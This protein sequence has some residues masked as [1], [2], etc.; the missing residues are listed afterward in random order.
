MADNTR[1]RGRA[2]MAGT[3]TA[4]PLQPA[5]P[6]A[7]PT[8]SSEPPA[9]QPTVLTSRKPGTDIDSALAMISKKLDRLEKMEEKL[10]GLDDMRV[11]LKDLGESAVEMKKMMEEDRQAYHVEAR[12]HRIV[13]QELA[14][15]Q[16]TNKRLEMQINGLFNHQKICNL[17]V[18]GKPEEPNENLK[19]FVMDLAGDMGVT[20]L[21]LG[22]IMTAYR[23]GKMKQ[24]TAQTRPRTIMVTF[25]NERVRN[26]VFYARSALKDKQQYRGIFVN[27]DVTQMTRRQRDDFRAVA[28]LARRDGVEVRVHTDGI[29]LNG[30]KHLLASP[31]TL[32]EEYTVAKA[33]TVELDGE[34]Y[35]SSESSFL[36]NFYPAPITDDDTVYM[37]A[38]H[39]YQ[40]LKCKHAQA[41]ER[42]RQVITAPSPLEA[43]RIADSV[44][45]SPEWRKDRDTVMEHVINAKFDQNVELADSLLGTG[46]MPLNEATS[47]DHFGIG[48]TILAREIR[49]ESYRGSNKL[50][51]I[52]MNKRA[53]LK[54][55]RNG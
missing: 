25:C 53:R 26:T 38:E 5:A 31:H 14:A 44:G 16:V 51:L 9:A 15:V 1:N 39:M 34:I 21:G 41:H 24:Q 43:K 3:P 18:D 11:A 30:T 22:D 36:S 10:E 49:D 28:A 20:A 45:T 4:T 8:G 7:V 46:D 55:A 2:S 23:M 37:S 19:R 47:N 6:T 54:A 42:M 52:L 12:A 35:F 40:A 29:I 13:R 32:P 48:V 27:D 17:R 50:G 33:K